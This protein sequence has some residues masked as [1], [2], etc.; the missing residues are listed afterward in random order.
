[1]IANGK[2]HPTVRSSHKAFRKLIKS[3]VASIGLNPDLFNGHSA[4]AGG[5]TDLFAADTPYYVVK[6]YGRWRSDAALIYYRCES[7]IAQRAAAAFEI[8]AE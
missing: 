8:S 3:S 1:M 4:R 2:L 6:K 7:S 5:A